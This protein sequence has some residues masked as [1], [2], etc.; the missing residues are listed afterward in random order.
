[1]NEHSM[2]SVVLAPF[3][4]ERVRQWPAHYF[5]ELAELIWRTHGFPSVVVGTRGQR[6]IANDIVRGLS[7]ERIKNTCGVWSW[8][9]VVSAID[10]A[11]YIVANNSGLAHL[12]AA[13]GR[14]TLC[15]FAA[16]HAFGE[17]MPRGPRAVVMTRD[18]ACSPCEIG[19]DL[20]PNGV[21]CMNGLEPSDIFWR[22]DE[23]WR[24]P[25]MKAIEA[26]NS[27][28]RV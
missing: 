21:A 24:R 23:I 20:C 4:N 22:F 5:R 25:S 16:S 26:S 15:L 1:M 13:R 8:N 28:S 27:V 19:T 18:I 2:P 9:E 6:V 11:P 14:W 17:W 12:A 7:S 3:A 10:T